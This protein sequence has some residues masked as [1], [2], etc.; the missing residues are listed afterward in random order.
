MSK[1]VKDFEVA[2]KR[3][4]TFYYPDKLCSKGHKSKRYTNIISIIIR[5]KLNII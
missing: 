2:K 4:L 3:G 5:F 1:I